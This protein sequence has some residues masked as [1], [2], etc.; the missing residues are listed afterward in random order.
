MDVQLL[1]LQNFELIKMKKKI[2]IYD[3]D[4]VICQSVNIKT[5]AFLSLYEEQ[6]IDIK[7]QIKEYHLKNGGVSRFE[8]IKYFQ[9][10]ILQKSVTKEQ[11]EILCKKF[12]SLVKDKV[13]KSKYILG[14][15]EFIECHSDSSKQYICTG[16]PE[17][18][19]LEIVNQKGIN[20]FFDGIYGSPEVKTDIINRILKESKCNPQDC[21]FFGDAMTDYNASIECNVPFVGIKN[22]DTTFPK[23][24]FL[25]NNFINLE[26]K[27]ITNKSLEGLI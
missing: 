12:S 26:L 15:R 9:S 25:I 11:I 3:F 19:I 14:A 13:I 23:N 5:E 7:N 22:T 24:T 17:D 6:S 1:L 16:T 18:E 2:I 10:N 8:K 27:D 4:G 20:N 21:I